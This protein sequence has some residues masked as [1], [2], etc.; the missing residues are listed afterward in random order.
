MAA[1]PTAQWKSPLSVWEALRGT[2]QTSVFFNSCKPQACSKYLLYIM[3]LHVLPLGTSGPELVGICRYAANMSSLIYI[4]IVFL[5]YL[6][7]LNGDAP[8]FSLKG[9]NA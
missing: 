7:V 2:G 4:I 9:V 6:I 5:C 1:P 8:R 3:I